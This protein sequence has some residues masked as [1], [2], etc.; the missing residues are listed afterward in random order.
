MTLGRILCGLTQW[1]LIGCWGKCLFHGASLEKRGEIFKIHSHLDMVRKFI[2]HI[3]LHFKDSFFYSK[4]VLLEWKSSYFS[5]RKWIFPSFWPILWIHN[6]KSSFKYGSRKKGHVDTFLK[7]LAQP[8][9][10][11]HMHTHGNIKF[12]KA[13]QQFWTWA[14]FWGASTQSFAV[15]RF[16]NLST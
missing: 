4:I 13:H 6:A 2:S 7:F 1:A 3:F 5:I 8:L 10:N 11:W 16:S 15:K 12:N 14:L 9:P